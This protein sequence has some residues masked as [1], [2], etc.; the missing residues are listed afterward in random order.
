MR[1]VLAWVAGLLLVS[2][3]LA[4][5]LMTTVPGD[6]GRDEVNFLTINELP[7][8]PGGV[9]TQPV[10]LQRSSPHDIA[11]PYRWFGAQ[12]ARLDVRVTTGDGALLMS[13][14][15]ALDDSRAPKWLQPLGDGSYWQ[16]H[17]ATFTSLPLPATA[18][19]TVILRVERV[20]H[21]PDK[22]VLFVSDRL[23]PPSPPITGRQPDM[24]PTL[25]ELP[26]QYLDLITEYGTPGPAVAKIPVYVSRLHSLAPPW[27]PF[28]LPELLLVLVA[29]AGIYL[30]T[31]TLFARFPRESEEMLD[32][33]PKP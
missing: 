15:Q 30:F 31:L 18:S 2:G 4:A 12:P 33:A 24:R 21:E 20:D 8:W 23:S 1:R 9:L 19:G 3:A 5:M 26:T 13:T 32:A 16:D 10:P 22:V 6:R 17:R 11:L 29:G 25:V 28:P 7:L 27:M 14:V